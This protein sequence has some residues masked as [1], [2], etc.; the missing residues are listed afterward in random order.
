M[1]K[2]Q[3]WVWLLPL[4]WLTACQP[5]NDEVPIQGKIAFAKG[6]VSI[7]QKS[8]KVGDIVKKGDTVQTKEQSFCV[9]QLENHAVISLKPKTTLVLKESVQKKNKERIFRFDQ[10]EGQS[11][12]NI[13]QK[14]LKYEVKTPTAVAGVRGTAFMVDSSEK[15]TYV[16]VYEGT[17]H[18]T[19]FHNHDTD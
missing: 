11:F 17:V 19:D 13:V 2:K 16:G 12:H 7:N 10:P 14:G 5:K 6:E 1:R 4:L 3:I 15:N 9:V 8:A 18:I